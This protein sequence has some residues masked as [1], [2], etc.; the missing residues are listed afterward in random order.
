MRDTG[1]ARCGTPGLAVALLLSAV[2]LLATNTAQAHAALVKSAPGS[3]ETLSRSPAAIVLKFNERV[4]PRFS[5]VTVE[6]A[7]GSAVRL[8]PV[9]LSADDPT[10]IELAIP[11]PLAAGTYT[12]RYRVLSQDGH[13]VDYGYQFR[14]ST[15]AAGDD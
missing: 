15:P 14:I 3:R 9:R 8:G 11:G 7:D 1:G 6:Q 12:V 10:Q 13:M 5:T 2:T 4:E